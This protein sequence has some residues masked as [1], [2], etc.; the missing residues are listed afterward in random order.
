MKIYWSGAALALMADVELRNRSGGTESLNT[1]LDK[2]QGC[3]LPARRLWSGP[4]LFKKLDTLLDDPQ[5]PVFMPLYRQ[6]ADARDFP[7][8]KTL[9]DD[10]G[11]TP[12]SQPGVPARLNASARLS[13]VRES[14]LRP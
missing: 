8:I 13:A 9:L 3:C 11:V 14:I 7:D 5:K 6:V 1:V 2:L 4:K 10:L 12:G